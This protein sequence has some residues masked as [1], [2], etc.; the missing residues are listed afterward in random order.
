MDHTL[1]ILLPVYLLL[2]FVIAVGGRSYLFYKRTGINPYKL[3]KS[4]NAHD[5][6]GASF[7]LVSLIVLAAV[8]IYS[9]VPGIY[10][11]LA[12]FEWLEAD[13]LRIAGIA[14]MF[15]ALIWISI[16]Q[17]QMG[18]SWRIGIDKDSKTELKSKGLFSISR[19]PIF[20]G[21]RLVLFGLFFAIPNALTLLSLILA[22]VL[23]QIQ[24]RLEEEHLLR[25]HGEEY[26]KYLKNVRRWI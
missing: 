20:L 13:W 19:N 22:D 3:G 14:L 23:M 25:L 11:Y 24:V 10:Y 2:I 16:A 17:T 12:P 26:G 7:R 15:V 21:M 5:F 8:L 9:F 6:V 4:G 18:R 1:R